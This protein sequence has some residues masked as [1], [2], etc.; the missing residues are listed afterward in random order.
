[1]QLNYFPE[2]NKLKECW[3]GRAYD[4]SLVEETFIKD[5]L[6]ETEEDLQNFS[7]L[8]KTFGVFVKRPSY[9]SP[10]VTRKPQ[11]LHAR[12]HLQYLNN[13]LYIGP[14]YEDNITDWLELLDNRSKYITL[15]NLCAPSVIRADRVYF[16]AVAWPRKRFEYFKNANPEINC[17]YE[18]FSSRDFD[19]ER[20]T[21][22]VFVVVK[23]GVII[24]TPQSRNLEYCFPNWDILYLDHNTQDI[25]EMNMAKNNFVWSPH[26]IPGEYKD[27]VG[28]SPETFFDVNALQLD[29]EHLMVTRYNKQV[30]DFLKKHKVEPIIVPFRHRYLWDGGLHCMTFDYIRDEV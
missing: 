3:V 12:D 17:I 6:D 7:K 10:D 9:K 5:I 14:Q 23:E 27:W 28:Y 22:G 21:D 8:L 18:R 11:L 29:S 20:H 26:Q 30:F 16:D 15:D 13:K 19:I 25:K 24:S 4:A 2:Y 1:M